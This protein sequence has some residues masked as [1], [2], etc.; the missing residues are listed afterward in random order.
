M[1]RGEPPAWRRALDRLYFDLPLR[2]NVDILIAE[3]HCLISTRQYDELI[4]F[5][6]ALLEVSEQYSD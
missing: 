5:F 4:R 6:L 2:T 1:D 3:Q